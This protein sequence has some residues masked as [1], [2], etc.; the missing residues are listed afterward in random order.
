M[1]HDK[2]PNSEKN[3]DSRNFAG[4]SKKKVDDPTMPEKGDTGFV[5]ALKKIG[6]SVWLT[7]MIIGAALA[8]ITALFLV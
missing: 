4:K 5:A 7:V 8:F 1:Q 2:K 6:F 3:V